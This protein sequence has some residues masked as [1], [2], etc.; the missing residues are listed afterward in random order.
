MPESMQAAGDLWLHEAVVRPEWVDY[1]FHMSECYYVLIFGNATDA[2]Y[3]HVGMDEN[4][5]RREKISVY[6]LEAHIRYL[7]E[8]H[9]GQR[10]RIATRLLGHDNK[11]LRLHHTMLDDEERALA[12]TEIAALHVDTTVPKGCAFHPG[13][14]ARMAAIAA[15]QKNLPPPMAAVTRHWGLR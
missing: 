6:T 7:I 5:R 13:P 15:A 2:F 1:N 3:D 9:E 8:A 10:L 11:R 14:L 4:F 12:V